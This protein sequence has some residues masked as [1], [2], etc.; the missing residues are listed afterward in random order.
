VTT[1]AA[2]LFVATST[3]GSRRAQ[4]FRPFIGC[5]PV[6]G[7]GGRAATSHPRAPA[8]FPPSRP[9]ERRVAS[10]RLRAGQVRTLGVSCRPNERLV[11]SSR[12]VAIAREA[13]PTP[14]LLA[15]VGV[16]GSEQGRRAR[17]R[18]SAGARLPAGLRIEAQVHALCARTPS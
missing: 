4:S 12:S 17:A 2:V 1:G 11:G 9:V 15:A 10:A 18:A 7:G 8:A 5:V 14:A 3:S 6:S 13:E 16:T